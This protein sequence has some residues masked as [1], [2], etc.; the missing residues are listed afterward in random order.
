MDPAT[1]TASAVKATLQTGHV[2]AMA[3]SFLIAGLVFGYLMRGAKAPAAA[4]H[5]ANRVA[6]PSVPVNAAVGRKTPTLGDMKQ[7]ADKQAAPL[8]TKLAKDPNNIALLMQV[9]AIYHTTHQFKEA[10]GYYEK[11]VQADPRNVALHTKLASS[12]Y[13]NGDVDEAIAQ[14]NRGLSYDPKDASSLFDLGMIRLQGKGDGKGALA[15]WQKLLKSNPQLS[16]DRKA[17]VQQLMAEVLT[18][19]GDLSAI[20]GARRQ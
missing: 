2:Y 8:L 1:T 9:G 6:Q 18:T 20:H 17:T 15:A 5:V 14:L 4:T 10:A 16:P 11:A 3:A 13:R 7:M 12:L 19:Q